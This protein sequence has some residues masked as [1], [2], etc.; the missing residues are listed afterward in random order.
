MRALVL[1]TVGVLILLLLAAVV[2]VGARGVM[3][4][5]EL[6]KIVPLAD[7]LKSAAADH[8][9]D[10][11][12]RIAE[13][14]SDHAG[15]AAELTG[16]PV[17][18]VAEAAP[19]VGDDLAAVRVASAQLSAV[20][21]TAVTPLMTIVRDLGGTGAAGAG[22]DLAAVEAAVSPL[23]T[24]ATTLSTARSEL[25]SIDR[26]AL[27][28]QLADG[29]GALRTAVGSGAD[30]VAG[31]ADAAAIL[32]GMLGADGP[33]SILLMLQNNAEV[34]TGGGITGSFAQLSADD[35]DIS[36]VAQA[37]S[38]E[39][40]H[41][42]AAIL[43]VP[44]SQGVLY[45]DVVGRFVQ[46][47]SMTSDFVLTARL[48]SAWWQD[49][50]GTAPD[51][52]V[53]IDPLVLRSLLEVL[54]PVTLADGSELS[55]DNVVARLLV[56]PYRMLDI[57]AQT[58]YQRQVTSA[59]F[60]HLLSGG[61]DPLAW[62]DGLAGPIEQGRVSVWSAHDDEQKVIAATAVAGPLAR[63]R[64]AGA[65]AYA[66]YFNDA[67]GGKMDGFLDTTIG[68]GVAECRE[69]GRRDVVVTVTLANAAPADIAGSP[70]SV[71]GGGVL[72]TAPGDIST[73]VTVAAPEG[74]FLAGVTQD[75]AA[76]LSAD[77]DDA[78]FASSVA[79]LTVARG[80]SATVQFRFIAGQPGPVSP[81][82][83]H[84]PLLNAPTFDQ[85]EAACA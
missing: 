84:T 73:S 8:D 83:L 76:V 12:Q 41:R 52:V 46:N 7:R 20:A 78:G 59:A 3:A 74:S 50:T 6:E 62:A 19:W 47:A 79:R 5:D 44:D 34:R 17:W 10:G 63:H 61:I 26:S 45:G 15:R 68:T 60:D 85:P 31:M 36:L 57:T 29:V 48:A 55:A 81:T 43:P 25:A 35:G 18:R 37:D 14:F 72:G 65:N 42:D 58:E 27:L 40:R 33:R 54:G 64:A 23:H 21:T 56:D 2:W 51:A 11:L 4:K 75:G 24:A 39:F 69:D 28:P 82:V 77:A 32:P 16:D 71:T 70:L 9:L 53:S 49:R 1:W 38:S 22:L 30:A 13:D 67:T 66:V 80:E